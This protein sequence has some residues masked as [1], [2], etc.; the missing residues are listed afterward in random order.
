MSNPDSN[1]LPNS[2]PFDS[3]AT[4]D[5]LA[6]YVSASLKI[7]L[8]V[9]EIQHHLSERGVSAQLAAAAVDKALGEYIG[10]QNL[11]QRRARRRK[12]ANRIL[13]ALVGCAYVG[14]ACSFR[15]AEFAAIMGTFLI[16]PLACIW[17][18][19]ELGSY[20]GPAGIVLCSITFPTPGVMLRVGGWL[21]LLM[22]AGIV[23]YAVLRSLFWTWH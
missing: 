11:P 8:K 9:S 3:L 23:G 22:P 19:D 2:A 1:P 12:L 14:L 15:D 20:I 4:P 5:R 10:Q 21:L 6:A 13:S 18:G 17:F 16:L 7:G